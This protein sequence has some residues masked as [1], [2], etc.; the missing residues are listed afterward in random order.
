MPSTRLV[1]PSRMALTARLSCS[2]SR[3]TFSGKSLESTTPLTNRKYTGINACASS[4]MKTRLTYSFTP[5][6]LSRL[7]MSIGA[8]LG[9]YSNCVYSV[10]PSTRLCVLANGA[11]WS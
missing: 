9:M 11:C 1:Q 7:N 5:A 6:A 8:L 10:A 2:S 3:E 4:M